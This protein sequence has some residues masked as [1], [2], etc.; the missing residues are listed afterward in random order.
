VAIEVDL[1]GGPQV[2]AGFENHGGPHPPRGRARSR[3]VA[4]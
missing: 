2:L 3:S 1:G 4:C